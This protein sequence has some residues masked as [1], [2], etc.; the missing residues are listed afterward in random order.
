MNSELGAGQI[1]SILGS[2]LF[3][4]DDVFKKIMVLSG[5]EKSTIAL[6]RMLLM[7]SNIIIL[8]EPTNHLD[9]TSKEILQ[10]ALCSFTGT[11]IIVSH[12]IDFLK[13][14]VNKV[15]EIRNQKVKIFLDGIDYYLQKRKEITEQPIH[16]ININEQKTTRKDQKRLEAEI[17][18]QKFKLTKDLKAD[19]STCEKRI[20]KLE[21]L[22]RKLEEDL[23]DSG[24]FSNAQI[25]KEK[26][27][28]YD[29]TRISLEGEYELWTE[30]THKIEE[31]ESA[32]DANG[33]G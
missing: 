16:L 27:I 14:I 31:I 32:F 24:I 26:N 9:F 17:R 7:Q 12:D 8:D 5:G 19:L 3:S 2:F 29:K 20:E 30:L 4:G 23:S 13:P 18:Q 11:L 6:A 33:G 1:R 25:A 21:V 28:E 22:K 15:F 10:K